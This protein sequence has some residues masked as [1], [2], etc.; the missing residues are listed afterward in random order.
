MLV[1]LLE[2][3]M[4][5]KQFGGILL[6]ELCFVQI[7]HSV[8]FRVYAQKHA[9]FTKGK[10]LVDIS[11]ILKTALDPFERD[12]FIQADSPSFESILHRIPGPKNGF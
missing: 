3:G 8:T 5:I 12:V 11:G 9:F 4:L 6:S 10:P 7:L 2:R 1:E